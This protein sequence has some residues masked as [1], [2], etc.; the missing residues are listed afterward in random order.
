M[1]RFDSR[2]VTLVVQGS[3]GTATLTV[4]P[5]APGRPF[6][7]AITS[8]NADANL[9]T[10]DRPLA[11]FNCPAINHQSPPPPPP[12]A[13]GSNVSKLLVLPAKAYRH[14]HDPITV[15]AIA[16]NANHTPIANASVVLAVYGDCD[17]LVS[18]SNYTTNAAGQATFTIISTKPGALSAVAALVD[19]KGLPVVSYPA[20]IIYFDEHS[21]IDE[22]EEQYYG[23]N[24][25]KHNDDGY[26]DSGYKRDDDYKHG[27]D[28]YGDSG[29]KR[30]DGYRGHEDHEQYGGGYQ[31]DDDHES[32]G[33]VGYRG[34]DLDDDKGYSR[35]VTER[36]QLMLAA[37]L[38]RGTQ[39]QESCNDTGSMS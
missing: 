8:I 39:L 10:T 6:A 33:G 3:I 35:C 30:D 18:R 32:S 34:D 28:G 4:R 24:H 13:I 17:P 7:A 25:H 14:V 11:V 15:T 22:R 20:H 1:G 27:D 23:P 9:G 16:L 31:G 29:Y 19:S 12:P 21:Y 5:G 38:L 36:V 26:G 2:G 37:L